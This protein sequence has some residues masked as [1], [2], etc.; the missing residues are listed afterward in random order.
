M[1]VACVALKRWFSESQEILSL[2]SHFSMVNFV[3]GTEEIKLE[4]DGQ[5][6]PRIYFLD[7]T[8]EDFKSILIILKFGNKNQ[9]TSTIL[10]LLIRLV[11]FLF[12][13]NPNLMANF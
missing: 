12:A 9:P 2:S 4:V 6:V 13:L 1:C 8:L 11:N 5:Y 3:Q 10:K 7:N